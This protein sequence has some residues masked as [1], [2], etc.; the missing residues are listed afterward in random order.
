M[1]TDHQATALLIQ[2]MPLL[3][4]EFRMRLDLELFLA[5]GGYADSV[6]EMAAR[7]GASQ[8]LRH[9]ADSLRHRLMR[10]TAGAHGAARSLPAAASASVAPAALP[11]AAAPAQAPRSRS[12]GDGEADGAGGRS[13]YVRSLR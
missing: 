7:D 5:D 12:P 13:R 1:K 3:M 9:L 8:R 4:R 6:L 10:A 2:M 11:G